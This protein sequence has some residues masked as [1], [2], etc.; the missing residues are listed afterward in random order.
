MRK[1]FIF[2]L[3]IGR[4]GTTFLGKLVSETFTPNKFIIE[5]FPGISKLPTNN[6]IHRTFCNPLNNNQINQF[7][8]IIE[9]LYDNNNII[10]NNE[11]NKRVINDHKQKECLIIKEVH[12]L[13]A[14]PEIIKKLDYKIV[15]ITR[16]TKRTIDSYFFGHKPKQRIYLIEEYKFINDYLLGKYQR[17]H[18]LLDNTLNNIDKNVINYIKRPKIFTNELNRQVCITEIVKIF[19]INWAESDNNIFHITHE[20]LSL[21][22]ID[23]M[24]QIYNFLNLEYNDETLNIIQKITHGNENN[25][26]STNKDSKKILTQP[27]KYLTKQQIIKINKFTNYK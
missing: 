24:K 19:L 5:P 12:S 8:N 27:Y 7:T 23:K 1:R 17:K 18:K 11:I 9:Q 22:P 10:F 13:L 6:K 21:Q 3:G 20:D 15:L 25:Y 16:D 2:I 26:Y 14:F 4:S